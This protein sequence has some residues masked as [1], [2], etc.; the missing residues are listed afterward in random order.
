MVDVY[1][2]GTNFF[3]VMWHHIIEKNANALWYT[4]GY[5]IPVFRICDILVPMDPDPRIWILGSVPLTNGSVSD[6]QDA[7]TKNISFWRHH[8][9]K[10]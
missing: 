10:I 5:N 3:I 4:V 1:G 9:S 7:A 6:F 8:S 2:A